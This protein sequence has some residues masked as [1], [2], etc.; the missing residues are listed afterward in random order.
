MP[1]P[2]PTPIP[3]PPTPTGGLK[4]TQTAVKSWSDAGVLVTQYEVEVCNDYSKPVLNAPVRVTTTHVVKQFWN[5]E[6]NDNIYTFPAWLVSNGGLQPGGSYKFG[7]VAD[8]PAPT[9]AFV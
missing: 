6:R 1:T 7:Y 3:T 9:V 5:A 8:G 4:V 2:T